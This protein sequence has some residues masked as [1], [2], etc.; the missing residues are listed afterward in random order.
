MIRIIILS[1]ALISFTLAFKIHSNDAFD[2]ELLRDHNHYVMIRE[3]SAEQLN[4]VYQAI[5]ACET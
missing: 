4:N 1:F 2:V 5:I 3:C